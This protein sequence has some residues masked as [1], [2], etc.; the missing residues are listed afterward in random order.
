MTNNQSGFCTSCNFEIPFTD[1]FEYRD[2][3]FE[4][5]FWGRIP[6]LFGAALFAY[7]PENLTQNIIHNLKYRNRSFVG[8]VLGKHLGYKIKK[9]FDD[10]PDLIIPV[11]LT[12]KRR[13]KRGF[14]QSEMIA[15]GISE[16]INKPYKENLLL[17][18]HETESQTG[19]SRNNRID[20]MQK[21]FELTST[22][23]VKDQHI[24][25]V[26]DVL[27]TGATLEACA[28]QFLEHT[29][30]ISMVTLAYGK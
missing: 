4:R 20:S 17:K 8:K 28:M 1:H 22:K 24:L 10:L 16:I 5:H 12:D 18:T 7:N 25:L 21:A 9:H 30:K 26:D 27:T 2:N 29:D 14:N 3:E 19:K 6:I 23:K 11:P 13:T 15:Q